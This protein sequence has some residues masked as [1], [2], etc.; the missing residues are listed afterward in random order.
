MI[1]NAEEEEYAASTDVKCDVCDTLNTA[2]YHC[3]QTDKHDV[4]DTSYIHMTCQTRHI[5]GTKGLMSIV[6]NLA[7]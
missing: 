4:P 1:G 7:I 6:R 2:S 5:Y 3:F